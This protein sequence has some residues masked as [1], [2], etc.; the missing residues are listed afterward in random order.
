MIRDDFK[1]VKQVTSKESRKKRTMGERNFYA[2]SMSKLRDMNKALGF[3]VK[4][5]IIL[6]S[7]AYALIL[8]MFIMSQFYPDVK[9]YSLTSFIV[10][11]CIY[12]ALLIFTILWYTVIKPNNLKKIERYKHE[13]EALSAKDLGK[14]SAAY[15]IY[16]EKYKQAV[17]DKHKADSEKARAAAKEAS[18]A[19]AA[20]TAGIA[21]EAEENGLET[22]ENDKNIDEAE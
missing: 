16:G 6:M 7:I 17:V 19:K 18:E 11:S 22:N 10:W 5:T 14:I 15:S 4:F 3:S 21:A 1:N 20:E 8:T 2:S 9:K 12:G 13:L